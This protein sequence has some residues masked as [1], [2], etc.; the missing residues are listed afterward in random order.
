M[1]AVR[2]KPPILNSSVTSIISD[3]SLVD[4]PI[5]RPLTYAV[6]SCEMIS[7]RTFFSLLAMDLDIILVS[8]FRSE[9]GLQFSM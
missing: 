3:I 1:S 7:G 5:K 4:S 2:I 8:T 6:W 9:I